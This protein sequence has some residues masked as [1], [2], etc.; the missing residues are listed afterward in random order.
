MQDC[1]GVL[2]RNI[3]RVS[4]GVWTL[5]HRFDVDLKMARRFADHKLLF[6]EFLAHEGSRETIQPGDCVTTPRDYAQ[7][8]AREQIECLH[9]HSK[10]LSCHFQE[11]KFEDVH[12]KPLL[13]QTD[14]GHGDRQWG[15]YLRETIWRGDSHKRKF[16][17]FRHHSGCIEERGQILRRRAGLEAYTKG[18]LFTPLVLLKLLLLLLLAL[19]H[20]PTVCALDIQFPDMGSRLNCPCPICPCSDPLATGQGPSF[21]IV[22]QGPQVAMRF[23]GRSRRF[24]PSLFHPLALVCTYTS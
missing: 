11:V 3:Q 21:V 8:S 23:S 20:I 9:D 12:S 1:G 7:G 17:K 22:P 2:R 19:W 6:I 13:N 16:H 14:F 24:L 10:P 18:Q 15:C 4:R 5:W